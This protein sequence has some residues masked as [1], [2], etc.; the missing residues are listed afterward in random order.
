MDLSN[1]EFTGNESLG[2]ERVYRYT[3]HVSA[4]AGAWQIQSHSQN[5]TD[6]GKAG[7]KGSFWIDSRDLTLRRIDVSAA[8]IPENLRLKNLRA[9]VD[10]DQMSIGNR[11][12]LLPAAATVRT[13]LKSTDF[14]VISYITFNHCRAFTADSTLSFD[15]VSTSHTDE[16]SKAELPDGLTIPVELSWP[17]NSSTTDQTDLL[18]ARVSQSVRY[19]NKEIILQGAGIEGHVFRRW[20]GGEFRIEIDRINTVNGWKPFYGRLLS[21]GG[22]AINLKQEM[23]ST[24][25]QPNGSVTSLV[26]IPGVAVIKATS[27]EEISAGTGMV[28][29]TEPLETRLIFGSPDVR[30]CQMCF[31][32]SSLH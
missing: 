32:T 29:T 13:K 14:E 15:G 1:I 31:G 16:I 28:W 26:Q 4:E 22:N 25:V 5:G 7:E 19:K 10:Y 11:R 3:F 8:D 9:I 12:V 18:K 2:E 30:N 21:I 24:T 20:V 17:I 6:D 23:H 27:G